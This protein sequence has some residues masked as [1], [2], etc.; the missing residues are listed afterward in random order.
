MGIL[1]LTYFF[2]LSANWGVVFS[3][4]SP[5]WFP[6]PCYQCYSA[7]V[8][9]CNLAFFPSSAIWFPTPPI[10][11][12]S[13]FYLTTTNTQLTTPS[14]NGSSKYGISGYTNLMS[15][16]FFTPIQPVEAPI[17][18][19][20]LPLIGSHKLLWVEVLISPMNQPQSRSPHITYQSTPASTL[21]LPL[22]IDSY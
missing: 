22:G 11:L 10:N 19:K 16:Q 15:L 18:C 14:Q 13:G 21:I 1:K 2:C 20:P 6:T 5:T 3:P 9:Q 12:I 17:R 4:S 8:K 7:A